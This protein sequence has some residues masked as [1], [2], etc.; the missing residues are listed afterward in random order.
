MNL[1]KTH[2][3]VCQLAPVCLKACGSYFNQKVICHALIW[4][5]YLMKCYFYIQFLIHLP[6]AVSSLFWQTE[7]RSRWVTI[8]P[9]QREEL[10]KTVRNNSE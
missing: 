10:G 5:W 6:V 4:R 8:R 9:Y 2:K 1:E 7:G 3:R